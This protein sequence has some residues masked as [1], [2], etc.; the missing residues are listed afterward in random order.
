MPNQNNRSEYETVRHAAGLIDR[1]SQGKIVL[2]GR[3]RAS[4]LHALLTNDIAALEPG[5]GCYAAYL[6]PQGR[7][8][9]DMRVVELGDRILLDVVPSV[10]ASL[11][12]RFNTLIFSED[13]Q[14]TDVTADLAELGVHGPGAVEV[15]AEAVGVSAAESSARQQYGSLRKT[16]DNAEVI[17]VRDDYLGEPGF[18]VSVAR[19]EA[20]HLQTK[21]VAAGALDI[22]ASTAE[23]LRV[24]AG[25]P[26]F[27]VDMNTETIPLEAGI[28]ERAISFT[29]GCYVGQEVIIR[30][31]HRGHGRIARKLVGLI[32]RG[33]EIPAAND[34]IFIQA[35]EQRIGEVTSAV[36]SPALGA[37]ALGYVRRDHTAPGTQ[38]GIAHGPLRLDAKV[39]ALPFNL[40]SA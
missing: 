3:D 15:L 32:I 4:F 5:T 28:E 7:M 37:I 21:I 8:I 38:V 25:R 6:T 31:L 33:A 29:K 17:V 34:L 35:G 19:A 11:T 40:R 23:I 20:E 18:D 30:V 1:S 36:Q 13:V 12:D 27:G 2:S 10:A 22:G 39:S 14:V 16:F 24:E 9:A 26:L